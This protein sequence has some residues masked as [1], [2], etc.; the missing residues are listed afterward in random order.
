MVLNKT[1]TTNYKWENKN[2]TE[3]TNKNTNKNR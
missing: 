2:K 3:T 1:E